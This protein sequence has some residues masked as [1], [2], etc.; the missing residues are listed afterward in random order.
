MVLRITTLLLTLF[1][2]VFIQAAPDNFDRAKVE[3]RQF[4]YH[5]RNTEGE[6]YCGCKFDWV[7]VSGGRVDLPSC[8][9]QV[10]AQEN[11]AQRIEWE[12]IL[13]AHSI[14]QARQCWQDGGRANCNR[15][16]PVFNVM[17]ADMHNLT[18]ALGE[19]NADRSNY[20][21]SV[22][23]GEPYRHG[24]CDVKVSFDQRSV[25]P[26]DEIKGRIARVYFYMHDRYDLT[27]ARAQQQ[28][29]IAWNR[30][31][32]VSDWER[33]RDQRIGA[34]MGH[35]NPFVTGERQWTLGHTNTADGVV[36]WL[37]DDHPVMSP[38]QAPSQ[39]TN[40]GIIRGNRNSRIYHLP[41]GCP[42]Y[43]AMADH[44]IVEFRTEQEAAGAGY[45]KAG[46]CR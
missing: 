19:V 26:R 9:Y 37:P 28:L 5:D 21:F 44:N 43:N 45:R 25:E 46:N 1:V 4:V 16:D 13:P 17:E 6:F 31:Y 34:R 12:H 22:L 33:E 2:S 32:P 14:G 24:L 18:A 23:P 41:Q 42:S 30:Q 20:R 10:R 39:T 40:S 7:G 11:R 29:M 38:Q 15:T 35:N 3:L 36:S 27:M 8:G